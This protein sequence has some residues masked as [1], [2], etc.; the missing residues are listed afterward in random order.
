MD[1]LSDAIRRL[2]ADGYEGNWFANS[3]H[4]L[5]CDESGEALDPSVLQIDH[6]LRFEGQSDPDDMTILF[7]LRTPSGAKGIYS[8]PFGAQTPAEDSSVIALMNRHA[9]DESLD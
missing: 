5:E 7:A 4:R 9:T 2:Q 3:D 8:A 6:M 1:T